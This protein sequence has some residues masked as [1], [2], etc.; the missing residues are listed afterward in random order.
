[1]FS[2]GFKKLI[3]EYGL[4]T[5]YGIAYG[6]IKGYMTSLAEEQYLKRIKI[7]AWSGSETLSALDRLL[8]QDTKK[9]YGILNVSF[10][11]SVVTIELNS[12]VK[13]FIEFIDWFYPQLSSLGAKGVDTCGA[14][15]QPIG[16]QNVEKRLIDDC[17]IPMHPT[18]SAQMSTQLTETAADEAHESKNIGRGMLG[19]VIGAILGAAVWALVAYAGYISALVGLL[20]GFLAKK[21]YELLGGKRCK[22][23]IFIVAFA[24]VLGV[25][26]GTAAGYLIMVYSELSQAGIT[27]TFDQF[28]EV[29][30]FVM[31]EPEVQ[32]EIVKDLALGLVFGALGFAGLITGM[33]K[34]HRK[35][36]QR[37]I[38]V[39]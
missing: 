36:T 20:I 9:K 22:A 14:C 21:G 34:E 10:T 18:C 32:I 27:F 25:L 13:C 7:A 30:A 1:M 8:D 16:E 26:I 29:F 3:R 38:V 2:P 28:I 33:A 24:S 15:G 12:A 11:S 35:S 4:V 5:A 31:Q 17:V 37:D 39:H 23:Q 6:E 19:A